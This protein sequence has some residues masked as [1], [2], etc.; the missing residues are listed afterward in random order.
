MLKHLWDLHGTLT[1]SIFVRFGH[2]MHQNDFKF[3]ADSR[4]V[5][6]FELQELFVLP[7]IFFCL[8]NI[9]GLPPG[10]LERWQ[11][12]GYTADQSEGLASE[13]GIWKRW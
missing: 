8:S 12:L 13:P 7:N 4:Y 6:K 9:V 5:V 11:S 3:G 10:V 1:W 2:I